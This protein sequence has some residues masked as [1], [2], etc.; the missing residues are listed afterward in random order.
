M[1]DIINILRKGQSI[2]L[3]AENSQRQ[4]IQLNKKANKICWERYNLPMNG[5]KSKAIK[6]NDSLNLREVLDIMKRHKFWQEINII[7]K[8]N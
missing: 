2:Q 4:H 1:K 6:I 3:Y 5:D 7:A 8:N